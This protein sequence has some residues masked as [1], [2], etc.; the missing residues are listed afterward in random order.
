MGDTRSHFRRAFLFFNVENSLLVT[1]CLLTVLIDWRCYAH[2][3]SI[4]FERK[5]IIFGKF[6]LQNIVGYP[7]VPILYQPDGTDL[8]T[9]TDLAILRE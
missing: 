6:S 5:Q 4:S 1:T 2:L 8:K 3:S 7:L 9:F